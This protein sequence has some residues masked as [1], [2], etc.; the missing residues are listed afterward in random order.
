MRENPS[1]SW[2]A[3]Q[4][5]KVYVE[6][7]RAAIPGAALQLEVIRSVAAAW[8]PLPSRI[9]D[10]GCGD[11]VLGRMLLDEYPAARVVFADFSEPMLEKVRGLV[12]SDPRAGIVNADFSA[13]GWAGKIEQEKPFDLIVSGFAIHHQP[14]ERKQSLYAEIHGLLSDGG[15]FLNLDQVSS[16]TAPIGELFDSFFLENMRRFV[17]EAG[18]GITMSE[19]ENAYYRDK[20]E[21]IPAPVGTQCRWLH[22]TGFQDVDCFFK[23][24]ELALF[25][26]RKAQVNG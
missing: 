25:G 26:G 7:V 19:I 14:D 15:V 12:G 23:T 18:P 24:F 20:K 3:G 22:E 10:L 2:Q 17:E 13:P 5:A 4:T 8:R 21:N 11:G 6:G 9:L 16:A 1:S